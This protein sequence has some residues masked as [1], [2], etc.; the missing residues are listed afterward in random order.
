M[1][2]LT[3][4]TTRS[5]ICLALHALLSIVPLCNYLCSDM[6][7]GDLN[8]K[9]AN[10]T[11]F[12]QAVACL[13]KPYY[14][15][16]DDPLDVTDA[17]AAY[18]RAHRASSQPLA[19]V[20]RQM[21]ML[22]HDAFKEEN[23]FLV[24]LG[25]QWLVLDLSFKDDSV[26]KFIN[27]RG[28]EGVPHMFCVRI[29]RQERPRRFVNYGTDLMVFKTTGKYMQPH[30]YDLR[31]VLMEGPDADALFVHDGTRWLCARPGEPVVP[32]QDLN[33]LVTCWAQ[34]LVYQRR[35]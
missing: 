27:A 12:V 10:A 33:R 35:I 32:V 24:A 25:M 5:H 13:T 14:S 19:V 16:G 1:R 7:D 28:L 17:T 29:D 11:A 4:D 2:T 23:N 9:R 31:A 20:F 26:G 22:A 8:R 15:P 30:P 3:C 21:L 34:V 6:M 18:K